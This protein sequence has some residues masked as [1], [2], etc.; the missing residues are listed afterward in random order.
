M[1]LKCVSRYSSSVGTFEPGQVIDV[2]NADAAFLL[3]DSP[4]SFEEEGQAPEVM[5]ALDLSAMST[6]TATGLIVPDRRMR[7]GRKRVIR[8][9]R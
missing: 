6:E 3:R 9:S 5:E 4:Q 1:K 7:G 8:G 2:N